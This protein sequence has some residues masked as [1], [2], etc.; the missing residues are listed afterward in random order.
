MKKI[1]ALNLQARFFTKHMKDGFVVYGLMSGT[2]LDGVDIAVCAFLKEG[3]TWKKEILYSST[4]PYEKEWSDKLIGAP[5][6]SG[7][8]LIL[9]DRAYGD[10]LGNLVCR[11][12][13]ES[14]IKP[15]LIAS[16]GHTIFH[17]PARGYSFQL[18]SGA[19]ILARTGITVVCD[20]RSTDIAYGGQGAPLVPIG[21]R[22]LF[23][24]YEAC[25]N[26]GGFA[27]ISFEKAGKRI[28]FDICPVN[29]V[30]NQFARLYGENFDTDGRFGR[31]GKV[32][33]S[34]L[35]KLNAI[36][37]Y[38]AISPKSLS[39]EWIESTLNPI[40]NSDSYTLDNLLGTVYEHIAFQIGTILKENDIGKVLMTG[41][42]TY[43][44][45]LVELI[46]KY[47]HSKLIIPER[48]IIEY[49]EALIF[50][51]MGL[52]CFRDEINCLSSVTGAIS[53]SVCGAIYKK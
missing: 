6:C 31:Q 44:K 49:K 9:L 48:V 25:L 28:A 20:F 4:I 12:I 36:P 51:F 23:S 5:S 2:S 10:Y 39:R 35:D 40:L 7:E 42:G 34:L 37:F 50:A 19:Q 14:G 52:L 43:N 18:G 45:F 17:N 8:E 13:T 38:K 30:L 3:D 21:D 47:C 33:S 24:E 32:N 41:G 27:N 53:D 46:R 11:I 26:M 15:S 16:H 1:I 29:I 22:L